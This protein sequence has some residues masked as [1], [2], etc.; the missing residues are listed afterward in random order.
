MYSENLFNSF[1]RP[2]PQ[3]CFLKVSR[4][5]VAKQENY[6]NPRNRFHGPEIL[7]IMKFSKILTLVRGS[8]L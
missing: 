2:V 6:T 4:P 5:G 8:G 7:E 3:D 1:G